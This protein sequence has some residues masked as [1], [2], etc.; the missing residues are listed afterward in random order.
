MSE[1]KLECLQC[2]LIMLELIR[3]QPG[4]FV[5]FSEMYCPVHVAQLVEQTR[6]DQ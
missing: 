1:Q 2:D 6:R 4:G 5:T 3:R